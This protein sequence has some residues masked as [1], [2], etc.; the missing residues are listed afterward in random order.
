MY[1]YIDR[2][3]KLPVTTLLRAIGYET[4]KDILS[5]FGIAEEV[6]VNKTNLKKNIGRKVAARIL[7]TWVED[8]V[9]EETGEVV[10]MERYNVV[11]D[12]DEELTEEN[13]QAI[14]DLKNPPKTML[15]ERES[16]SGLDYSVITNTLQ[17]DPSNSQ[18]EAVYHIYRQLRS[19]DPMDEQSA[20]EVINN[21]FFS[22]KRYDLGLS[23]IHI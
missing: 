3:K 21:L 8:L 19:Q 12:R 14:L 1:A 7:D 18:K 4:D 13:I 20:Q 5:L 16:E 11:V 22:D 17:K 10:S 6:K 9:D 2:K 23:L 15:L